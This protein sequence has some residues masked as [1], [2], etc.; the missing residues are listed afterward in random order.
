VDGAVVPIFAHPAVLFHPAFRN[1][2][3]TQ[4]QLFLSFLSFFLLLLLFLFGPLATREKNGFEV[5]EG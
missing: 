3:G 2:P 5:I 1:N 4:Q